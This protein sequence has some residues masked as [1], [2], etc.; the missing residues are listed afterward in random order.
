MLNF[1]KRIV[2][3]TTRKQRPCRGRFETLESRIL[4]SFTPPHNPAIEANYSPLPASNDNWMNPD[5]WI[6]IRTGTRAQYPPMGES[7]AYFRNSANV[8]VNT[9][10]NIGNIIVTPE[11]GANQMNFTKEA[12]SARSIT[13]EGGNVSMT[14]DSASPSISVLGNITVDAPI[15]GAT[16]D[17]G[18]SPVNA[19]AVDAGQVVVANSGQG[20]LEIGPNSK[21]MSQLKVDSGLT[22]GSQARSVGYVGLDQGSDLEATTSTIV[23]GNLG[24]GTLRGYQGSS[25]NAKS[26]TVA[27]GLSSRGEI[28]S[29]DGALT[30][31]DSFSVASGEKSAGTA[32][33]QEVNEGHQVQIGGDISVASGKSSA[34]IVYID[35]PVACDGSMAIG[36]GES[37]SS[38]VTVDSGKT[39]S[40]EESLTIGRVTSS[41]GSAI[42]SLNPASVTANQVALS[43][44]GSLMGLGT[45]TCT[46]LNDNGRL[47]PG[48]TLDDDD[49][50]TVQVGEGTINIKGNLTVGAAGAVVIDIA[51]DTDYDVVNVTGKATL[52][53]TLQVRLQGFT[54]KVGDEFKV[55]TANPLATDNNGVPIHFNKDPKGQLIPGSNGKL[56]WD[57]IYSINA[58]TLKVIQAKDVAVNVTTTTTSQYDVATLQGLSSAEVANLVATIT[59]SGP[60]PV[61]NITIATDGTVSC[62]GVPSL[63]GTYAVRTTFYADAADQADG[64]E[65][66]MV[67]STAT[68][69]D[70]NDLTSSMISFVSDLQFETG[71]RYNTRV[72]TYTNPQMCRWPRPPSIGATAACRPPRG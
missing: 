58:V 32:I 63:P 36:S 11:A 33:F 66:A 38:Y 68:V 52:G 37:S 57:V 9:R 48:D 59:W 23:V 42:L 25:I 50:K 8:N 43:G 7:T 3:K 5:N 70:G 24:D 64:Q 55:L 20:R 45:I 19:F 53:G 39:L 26:I 18:E 31:Q 1:K 13:V 67:D 49:H 51:S 69:T 6:N 44:D 56:E 72:A 4:L 16:L 40:I 41:L 14:S 12:T 27:A 28:D 54:P 2:K 21:A 65:L 62:T 71:Y 30:V 61:Q 35:R 47:L 17:I 22:I 60:D 34:A 15:G 29:Y 46:S 10:G